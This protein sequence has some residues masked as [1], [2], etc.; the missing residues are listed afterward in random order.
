MYIPLERGPPN[1]IMVVIHIYLD[2]YETA[3]YTD[4]KERWGLSLAGVSYSLMSHLELTPED[5]RLHFIN[6]FQ[7]MTCKN[8]YGFNSELPIK[9]WSDD[10]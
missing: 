4:I 6:L 9:E 8:G 7:K 3:D 10:L 2:G 1:N 5:A